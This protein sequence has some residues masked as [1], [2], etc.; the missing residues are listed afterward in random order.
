M[1]TCAAGRC[2]QA[3]HRL[4]DGDPCLLVRR[5]MNSGAAAAAAGVARARPVPPLL[6]CEA[7]SCWLPSIVVHPMCYEGAGQTCWAALLTQQRHFR[8]CKVAEVVG[9]RRI[10]FAL[11]GTKPAGEHNAMYYMLCTANTGLLEACC[12]NAGIHCPPGVPSATTCAPGWRLGCSPQV[13][14]CALP[15]TRLGARLH[16]LLNMCSRALHGPL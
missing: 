15:I 10:A 13:R 1:E 8:S 16:I 3:L 7:G 6:A 12:C 5:L 2:W 14:P 11:T 4:Y 9:L